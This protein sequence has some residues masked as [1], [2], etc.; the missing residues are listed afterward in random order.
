MEYNDQMKNRMKRIE[1]QVR[2]LMKMME[3]QK[4]CRDV[5]TQMSAVRSALDRTAALI[6][7]TNLEQCIRDE[8]Q[9]GGSSEDL[10]KEAVNLLVKSR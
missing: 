6:V 7:S 9:A 1:G 5:V 3:E 8:K 4:D 2:G 10:I